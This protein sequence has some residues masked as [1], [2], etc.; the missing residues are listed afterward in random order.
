MKYYVVSIQRCEGP[1]AQSDPRQ[2]IIEKFRRSARG[3]D[4]GSFIGPAP[5]VTRA[6]GGA[7]L[8]LAGESTMTASW[9]FG[10]PSLESPPNGYYESILHDLLSRMY[11]QFQILREAVPSTTPAQIVGYIFAPIA[12]VA[13]T[14]TASGVRE[15]SS[16]A[17]FNI[18]INEYDPS[19]NGPVSWWESGDA[20]VTATGDRWIAN[21]PRENTIGPND[22][23]NREEG[24]VGE[25]TKI[26]AGTVALASVAYLVYKF[27]GS[28][29]R[30][31]SD[32]NSIPTS[33]ED[34]QRRERTR[35]RR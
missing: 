26:I 19:V 22:R 14:L 23:I 1:T 20:A 25:Y 28:S 24:G 6:A 8:A 35:R 33:A 10:V 13:A 9:L 16:P 18:A 31:V 3:G 32:T 30:E 4:Y 15:L 11:D 27:S 34:P 29:K 2:I 7:C 12:T 17:Y 21:S 5:R